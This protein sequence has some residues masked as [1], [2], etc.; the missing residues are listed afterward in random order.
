MAG[1]WLQVPSHFLVHA[2]GYGWLFGAGPNILSRQ[3]STSPQLPIDKNHPLTK[4]YLH[5]AMRSAVAGNILCQFS[6]FLLSCHT[7]ALILPLFS[8]NI[9]RHFLV[10]L[11]IYSIPKSCRSI[12]MF[13]QLF[14]Y[15]PNYMVLLQQFCY[16]LLFLAE[17]QSGIE[18]SCRYVEE[19]LMNLPFI[20][21]LWHPF[22]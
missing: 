18:S 11:T 4:G 7:I 3:N 14:E 19:T 9:S 1:S 10:F 5:E 16:F 13:W 8:S 21:L 15:L 2:P 6:S 22:V 20:A 17:L 12:N